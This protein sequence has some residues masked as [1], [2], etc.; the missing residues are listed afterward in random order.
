MSSSHSGS[1]AI[2]PASDDAAATA[3]S[4][5]VSYGSCRST[6]ARDHPR[7]A[8]ATLRTSPLAMNHTLPSSA[9]TRVRSRLTSSTMPPVSSRA[10]VSPTAYWSSLR[11]IRP[12]SRSL[13]RLCAPK[14]SAAPMTVAPAMN[15]PRFRLNTLRSRGMA[16]AHT[17]TL[18]IPEAVDARA[19]ARFSARSDLASMG[20]RVASEEIDRRVTLAAS[21]LATTASTTMNRILAG[22]RITNSAVLAAKSVR[23]SLMK[24]LYR[25]PFGM[26]SSLRGGPPPRRAPPEATRV[27][28]VGVKHPTTTRP[29]ASRPAARGYW[30]GHGLPPRGRFGLLLWTCLGPPAQRGVGGPAGA[31]A[32]PGPAHP[33]PQAPDVGRRHRG[34]CGG[35]RAPGLRA[36]PRPPRPRP[37]AA[38]RRPA[39]RPGPVRRAGATP[40]RFEGMARLPRPHR[41]ADPAA[42]GRVA[43]RG[44]ARRALPPLDR[45]RGIRGGDLAG[46]RRLGTH[47]P[48]R[49]YEA[50]PPRH[51]RGDHLRHDQRPADER[52]RRAQHPGHPGA[53]RRLVPL[54][55]RRGG[56][57]GTP[58][59]PERVPGRAASALPAGPHRRRAGRELGRGRHPLL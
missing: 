24:R 47:N 3:A 26:Q 36:Q 16:I 57:G 30:C 18:A 43:C 6:V 58:A 29:P 55:A 54:R 20:A 21:R 5:S 41:R 12:A 49:S 59:G 9:R 15:G 51:R 31:V 33:S 1:R 13:T 10:I 27:T 23:P 50:R 38:H 56:D 7:L 46:H 11:I 45:W 52:R 17:T 53:P 8:F 32:A 4:R 44:P 34:R 42:L 2:A 39:L 14:P 28:T 25:Y 22:F 35:L 40:H 48:Q 19:L 37:T